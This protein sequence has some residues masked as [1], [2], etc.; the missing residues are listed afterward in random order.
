MIDTSFLVSSA[1][2]RRSACRPCLFTGVKYNVNPFCGSCSNCSRS[3]SRFDGSHGPD[4]L[5][6]S[7]NVRRRGKL[8]DTA[9]FRFAHHRTS[10]EV[11]VI[12][13]SASSAL[14]WQQDLLLSVLRQ[15]AE[16]STSLRCQAARRPPIANSGATASSAGFAATG[17]SR[18]G[19]GLEPQPSATSMSSAA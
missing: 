2:H 14:G 6:H 7:A 17:S 11:P 4:S 13:P 15:V 5:W 10:D 18:F 8:S 19:A 12:Y 16:A 9:R 1:P 3:R